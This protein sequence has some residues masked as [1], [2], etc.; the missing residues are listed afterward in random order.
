MSACQLTFGFIWVGILL[1][2]GV[3]VTHDYSLG[4]N[5]I[6]IL[7]TIVAMLVILF[8]AILFATLVAQMISLVL[9]LISEIGNRLA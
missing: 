5:I 1:F 7:G 8:V 3:L 2:F 9:S 4:K 6:T